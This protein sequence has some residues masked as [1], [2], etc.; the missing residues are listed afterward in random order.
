M[1]EP[2]KAYV[3]FPEVSLLGQRV[4]AF[5]MSTPEAKIKAIASLTFPRTLRQ[6][7]TYLGMTGA[8]RQ[9]VPMYAKK[10]EPLQIRKTELL[11]GSPIKGRPHPTEKEL[12]S[13]DAIQA[14]FQ[15]PQW[16]AHWDRTRRLYFDIDAS[17]EGGHGAMVFHIK[18][19]YTHSNMKQ[20]PPSTAVEP[21]MF[22]SRV[23]TPAEKHYWATELEISCLVW[24]VRKIRHMV[25][26]APD[27]LTPVAYTDH[28][29]TINL[30]TSL[31]SASPDRLNLRG[32]L[33]ERILRLRDQIERRN[34]LADSGQSNT[35]LLDALSAGI[36]FETIII[37][38]S[39][40]DV[41]DDADKCLLIDVFHTMIGPFQR[42]TSR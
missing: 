11:R 36:R 28:I 34:Q 23:L 35:E 15:D 31:S 38:F 21:I 24:V 4:D 27:D 32:Q 12:A 20:P 22:L 25:E 2:R 41:H 14:V 7:E 37:E 16:L 19:E 13:F 8:L 29:A 42:Q 18:R 17:Q 26:A 5:G 40:W 6:L 10:S 9:Y 30:A 1:L 3:A 33:I 39:I